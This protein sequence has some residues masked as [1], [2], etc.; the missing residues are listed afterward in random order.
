MT[1]SWL[2]PGCLLL[3]ASC[4]TTAPRAD[5][6]A[7]TELGVAFVGERPG[8]VRGA[9]GR[10]GT[11]LLLLRVTVGNPHAAAMTIAIRCERSDGSGEALRREISVP[12]RRER[13]VTLSGLAAEPL[14]YRVRCRLEQPAAT[15][16]VPLEAAAGP[17]LEIEVPASDRQLS[18]GTRATGRHRS[19]DNS[20]GKRCAPRS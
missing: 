5:R 9:A 15:G 8:L 2:A 1:R 10:V 17:W 19:G 7:I 11:D 3:V 16:R 14:V 4:A 20:G 6:L 13:L 12:A 18:A